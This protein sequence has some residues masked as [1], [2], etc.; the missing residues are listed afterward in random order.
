MKQRFDFG[1]MNYRDYLLSKDFFRIPYLSNESQKGFCFLY[2]QSDI[3]LA[4]DIDLSKSCFADI[5]NIKILMQHQIKNLKIIFYELLKVN[6][7]ADIF[8]ESDL[9]YVKANLSKIIL[10]YFKKVWSNEQ[11]KLEDKLFRCGECNSWSYI[12][13]VQAPRKIICILCYKKLNGIVEERKLW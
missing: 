13:I 4:D 7:P 9:D 10:Y 8:T 6:A 2:D 5:P 1:A 12:Q 3:V 11:I